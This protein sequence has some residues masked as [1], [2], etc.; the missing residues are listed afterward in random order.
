MRSTL[1]PVLNTLK[2]GRLTL[3]FAR[4]FGKKRV[5]RESNCVV[6]MHKWRGEWYMTD[7]KYDQLGSAE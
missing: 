1:R 4:L 6:T 5:E 3:M 2:A 7:Y